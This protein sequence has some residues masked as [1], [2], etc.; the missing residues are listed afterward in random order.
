VTGSKRGQIVGKECDYGSESDV[1]FTHH[2]SRSKRALT[3]L[4]WKAG[5][6]VDMQAPSIG[7]SFAGA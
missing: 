6:R 1:L 3:E 2:G 7:T 5:S 4:G